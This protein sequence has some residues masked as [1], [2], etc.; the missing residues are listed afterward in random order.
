MTRPSRPNYDDFPIGEPN[1]LWFSVLNEE[2]EGCYQQVNDTE[3]VIGLV[4]T[5]L[6]KYN[7]QTDR[8]NLSL[9]LYSEFVKHLLKIL[10]AI[11]QPDGHLIVVG[12]RGYGIT[13]L[14]KLAT[15]IGAIQYNGMDMSVNFTDDDWLSELRKIITF[16]IEED[17]A[18]CY[19]VDEYRV[20]ND[21]WY[22]DLET[23]CK[24]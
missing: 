2:V 15:F 4:E 22:K 1:K 20:T 24:A 11:S 18:A 7:E 21:D 19:V 12:L 13:Q 3:N 6:D 5:W 16:S 14:I 8:P 10:R 9:I 23:L 17:K